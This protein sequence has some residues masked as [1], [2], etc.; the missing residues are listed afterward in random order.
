MLIEIFN[1]YIQGLLLSGLTVV[2]GSGA[3]LFYRANLEKDKTV[4]ARLA[5]LYDILL[6]DLVITPI[7]AF[8][9]MAIILMIKA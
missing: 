7:L 2:L 9:F 5:F 1:L 8:A 3:W 6:I 4:K